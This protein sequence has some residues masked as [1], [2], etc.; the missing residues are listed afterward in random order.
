MPQ[1]PS[2][3]EVI[4]NDNDEWEPVT[5]E[6]PIPASKKDDSSFLS[7]VWE[8]AN[9]P[10]F[11]F[12]SRIGKSVSEFINPNRE[13]KGLSGVSSAFIE[14]LGDVV[15]GLTSPLNFATA[16]SLGAATQAA[17]YGLPLAARGLSTVGK[18]L[19]APVAA[20]G[21]YGIATGETLPEK[22]TG[23][24]E[25][26]GGGLGMRMPKPNIASKVPKASNFADEVIPSQ[27]NKPTIPEVLPESIPE[28]Q[29]VA[30]EPEI[31]AQVV[32]Q[33]DPEIEGLLQKFGIHDIISENRP[34]ASLQSSKPKAILPARLAGAKP[35][36]NIGE[37]AYIP[38]FEDDLD[39][40]LFIIAQKNLSKANKDYVKFITENTGMTPGE[41]FKA[42]QEVKARI[43][44]LVTGQEPGP[45]RIPSSKPATTTDIKPSVTTDASLVSDLE[46]ALQHR[47]SGTPEPPTAI[48]PPRQSRPSRAKPVP[49]AQN[50]NQPPIPPSG[51]ISA[52]DINP[53]LPIEPRKV[54]PEEKASNFSELYNLPRGL[55]SVD[56]PFMTSAAFRQASPLSWTGDWFKA[57]KQSAKAYGSEAS[58]KSIQENIISSK[59]FKPRY[60]PIIDGAGNIIK[61]K[62]GKSFAEEI[63]L[64]MSDLKNLTTREEAIASSW[65]EKIPGYGKAV[66][67]SNR[68]YTSFLNDLRKN[69]LEKLIAANPEMKNNL[70]LAK[71]MAEFI[72]NATGRGSLKFRGPGGR[73]ADL[74]Q[75][76]KILSNAMFSPRLL[77]SRI[78][79][80]NP[81]TYT[82]TPPEVR[83][84][85]IKGLART[86]G[87]WG[88][89]AGLA[90]MGG[91]AVTK[92]PNSS[93]FG[94][95][96]IGNTRLDPG[97]GFQQVLVLTSRIRPEIAGGGFTTVAGV[98]RDYGIGYKA[99]TRLTTAQEFAANK[100]HPSARFAYDLLNANSKQPFDVTDEVIQRAMPMLITDVLQ[101]AEEDPAVLALIAPL[102]SV[103]IGT[104]TFEPGSFDKP[105]YSSFVEDV[106]GTPELKYSGR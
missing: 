48:V 7:S 63:G 46:Q 75:S 49:A 69:T 102:S 27:I 6:V 64:K 86:I 45:I 61:Y 81:A 47:L 90:E 94:K 41:A 73:I 65:A 40:A 84:E 91:A 10:M 2:D 54:L 78:N 70:P 15:S 76:S 33:P 43:K 99:R 36:Y 20:H 42:G 32:S 39:K 21:A 12:P 22:I 88:A 72:N 8:S 79:F 100:L 26:L 71:E 5:E 82:Q 68:A 83:N 13:T 92:D 9:E 44:S 52:D 56:L 106:L 18:G 103:G 98:N 89:F 105:I 1:K 80:L 85:Y 93:D 95:I 51:L 97:A 101:A 58:H 30:I 104:Q 28:S 55:M 17:K 31:P 74:E 35:R 19:A 16:G 11:T 87:S 66:R 34:V 4:N 62:E 53:E 37:S 50:N 67:A 96:R 25:L 29:M 38:E 23:G 59:Y 3:W 14:S 57:W 60:E 24:I 77:A